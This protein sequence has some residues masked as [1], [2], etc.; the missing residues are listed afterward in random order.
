VKHISRQNDPQCMN[1]LTGILAVKVDREHENH[2]YVR[3]FAMEQLEKLMFPRNSMLVRKTS[4][5]HLDTT[6]KH[7]N[8]AGARGSLPPNGT[9]HRIWFDVAIG[10]REA[11]QNGTKEHGDKHR[12]DI[13]LAI[14]TMLTDPHP[15][16]REIALT[17]VDLIIKRNKDYMQKLDAKAQEEYL[18]W[19]TGSPEPTGPDHA[20][21]FSMTGSHLSMTMSVFEDEE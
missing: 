9:S 16:S 20:A 17:L 21:N 14:N 18:S 19:K 15:D 1:T 12:R 11:P 13:L 6:T 10:T 3:W 4:H 8:R 5:A 2:S 7:N